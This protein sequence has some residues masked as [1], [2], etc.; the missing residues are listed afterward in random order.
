MNKLKHEG[1]KIKLTVL[2]IRMSR[3]E[4]NQEPALHKWRQGDLLVKINKL[5]YTSNVITNNHQ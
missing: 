4:E 3:I 1:N 5:L 2:I